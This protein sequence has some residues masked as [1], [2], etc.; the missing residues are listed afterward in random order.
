MIR[1]FRF[2]LLAAL[3]CSL[4][5]TLP[6]QAQQRPAPTGLPAGQL[7]LHGAGAGRR[8]GPELQ[9]ARRGGGSGGQAG[10]RRVVDAEVGAHL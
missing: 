10:E 8:V 4:L 6:T 2:W 3:G 1:P 9:A 5:A 7:H